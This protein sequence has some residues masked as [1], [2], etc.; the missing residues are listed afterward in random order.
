[1]SS[2]KALKIKRGDQVTVIA[3]DY[4]GTTGEVVEVLREQN[5]VL[6]QGVNMRWKHK[7]PTQQ[8]PKGERVQQACPIHASNVMLVDPETGKRTRRRPTQEA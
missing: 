7:R 8:N 5:R 4:A 1:M 6:V 3:G 2:R